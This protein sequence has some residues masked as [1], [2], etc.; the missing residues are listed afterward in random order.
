MSSIEELPKWKQGRLIQEH[1]ELRSEP[2]RIGWWIFGRT[3]HRIV[4][5]CGWVDPKTIPD[6]PA[7]MS[8]T[9]TYLIRTACE[10]HLL[11]EAGKMR[12]W[13]R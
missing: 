3:E 13:R 11:D 8:I 9:V 7:E 4:C 12:R 10:R 6:L 1:R 5:N 2:V